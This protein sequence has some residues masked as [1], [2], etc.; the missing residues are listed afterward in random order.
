[1]NG[2]SVYYSDT[3]IKLSKSINLI[4]INNSIIVNTYI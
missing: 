3:E 4:K 2:T 1:M